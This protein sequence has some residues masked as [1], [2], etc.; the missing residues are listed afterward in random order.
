MRPPPFRWRPPIS[1]LNKKL[2][3]NLPL[4]MKTQK[5]SLKPKIPQPNGQYLRLNRFSGSGANVAP[6]R[7]AGAFL[8]KQPVSVR[9]R[10]RFLVL[11]RFRRQNQLDL[12]G[13]Q[14][15]L[16]LLKHAN[17]P[18][19]GYGSAEYKF[20]GQDLRQLGHELAYKAS[21]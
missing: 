20:I 15:S 18:V 16:L 9:R 21:R 14:A 10:R 7:Q 2:I 5:P 3:Q 17:G 4:W 6:P 1:A 12:A 8:L 13:R 11:D 19:C